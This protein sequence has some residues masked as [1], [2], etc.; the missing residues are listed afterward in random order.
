MK[1]LPKYCPAQIDPDTFYFWGKNKREK[2]AQI[3]CR[4]VIRAMLQRQDAVFY[5]I[6][7]IAKSKKYEK[8]KGALLVKPTQVHNRE[9]LCGKSSQAELKLPEQEAGGSD[10]I[11]G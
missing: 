6:F 9:E 10:F 7:P 4:G 3:A 11:F 5:E 8:G 1:N 2:F